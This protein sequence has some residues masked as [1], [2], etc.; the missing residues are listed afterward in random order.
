MNNRQECGARG[1]YTQRGWPEADVPEATFLQQ[2]E[3]E[4]VP[5]ALRPDSYENALIREPADLRT[6]G[7]RAAVIRN[8]A[9]TFVEQG[10]Q[11]IF[12]EH[13]ELSIYRD[14]GQPCI[15]RLLQSF[16]EQGPVTRLC[17]NVSVEIVP[18]YTL[19]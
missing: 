6:D 13:L 12:D 18:F 17:Q 4:V 9:N 3:F 16:N 15:A 14:G 11:V 5:T 7:R 19:S 8:E 1:V 10:V 2:R